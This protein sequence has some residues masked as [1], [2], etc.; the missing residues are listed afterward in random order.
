MTILERDL[1]P[2]LIVAGVDEARDR[3]ADGHRKR[4]AYAPGDGIDGRPQVVDIE[5][6]RSRARAEALRRR[7]VRAVLRRCVGESR[8]E[9][10]SAVVV[11]NDFEAGM[12]DEPQVRVAERAEPRVE[13]LH[14][15]YVSVPG[16]KRDPVP[17]LVAAEIDRAGNRLERDGG[18]R[19]GARG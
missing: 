12:V 13:S 4:S 1:I 14:V 8:F 2:V 9:T 15:E 10:G 19:A 5:R 11:G 7:E 6:E 16:G 18:G 3:L 17:V